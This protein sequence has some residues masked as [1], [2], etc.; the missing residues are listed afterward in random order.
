MTSLIQP[1][2]NPPTEQQS[3]GRSVSRLGL[4]AAGLHCVAGNHAS[5]SSSFDPI[6]RLR[7]IGWTMA[8]LPLRHPDSLETLGMECP[9]AI[10]AGPMQ[11]RSRTSRLGL[12]SPTPLPR[13][14]DPLAHNVCK[15]GRTDLPHSPVSATPGRCPNAC[16]TRTNTP[17]CRLPLDN[18][19]CGAVLLRS[20]RMNN[21]QMPPTL[22]LSPDDLREHS[23]GPDRP[24]EG[25]R[26][27]VS[28]EKNNSLATPDAPARLRV[29]I[30][31]LHR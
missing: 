7:Q 22:C 30:G 1:H 8:E 28:G 15:A 9:R 21:W 16:R 5:V 12:H 6:D 13:D 17:A 4:P 19:H 24:G 23:I 20:V 18:R 3:G 11:N 26:P 27:G 25:G 31:P 10:G 2:L 14:L 29:C